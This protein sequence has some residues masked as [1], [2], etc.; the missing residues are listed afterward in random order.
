[1]ASAERFARDVRR[2]AKKEAR[3]V[4]R[5][6]EARS[7]QLIDEMATRHRELLE[8]CAALEREH[9][10]LRAEIQSL[11][12]DAARLGAQLNGALDATLTRA[13]AALSEITNQGSP[14]RKAEDEP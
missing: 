11:R 13:T 14:T 8:A 2:A 9:S 4:I 6:A 12:D 3:L 5:R 7:D 1:M 10:Q